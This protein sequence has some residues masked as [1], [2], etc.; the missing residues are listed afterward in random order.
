MNRQDAEDAK[1]GQGLFQNGSRAAGPGSA[2]S[3]PSASSALRSLTAAERAALA[4]DLAGYRR[5]YAEARREAR[6]LA[7]RAV[8]SWKAHQDTGA[9]CWR[10]QAL[11]FDADAADQEGLAKY[12]LSVIREGELEVEMPEYRPEEVAPRDRRAVWIAAGFVLAAL[13]LMLAGL[14]ASWEGWL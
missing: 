6:W 2:A 10:R 4:C 13:L 8:N 5:L 3:A 14:V 1:K 9:D 12:L 7:R 11:A